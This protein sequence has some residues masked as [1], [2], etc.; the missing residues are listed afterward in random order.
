MS[1]RNKARKR[2]LDFLYEADIK[3]ASAT[4]LFSSRGAKE[5]SQEPYVLVLSAL[6]IATGTKLFYGLPALLSDPLKATRV[7]LMVKKNN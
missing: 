2:A 1:A 6:G 5:L 7:K 4:E 3:K